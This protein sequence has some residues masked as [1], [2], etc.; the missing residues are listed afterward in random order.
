MRF[1]FWLVGVFIVVLVSAGCLGG[2]EEQVSKFSTAPELKQCNQIKDDDMKR[3]ECYIKVAK[4]KKKP[5]LC[6][7]LSIE[8]ERNL[9]YTQI[10]SITKD[11]SVCDNIIND[12]WRKTT[13][14]AAGS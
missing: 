3:E 6:K 9:C 8:G 12:E 10:A 13:C 5:E 7:E 4:V 11:I 2:G 1:S 14:M